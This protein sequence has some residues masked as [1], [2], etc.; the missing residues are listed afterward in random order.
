MRKIILSILISAILLPFTFAGELSPFIGAIDFQDS[1]DHHNAGMIG[2]GYGE[3]IA[4]RLRLKLDIGIFP[5]E[6]ISTGKKTTGWYGAVNAQYLFDPMFSI[7]PFLSAG[8]S[9]FLYADKLNNEIWD[10]GIDAGAGFNFGGKYEYCLEFRN[11]YNPGNKDSDLIFMFGMALDLSEK[12]EKKAEPKPVA[13]K[14]EKKKEPVIIEDVKKEPIVTAPQKVFLNDQKI[15]VG[16]FYRDSSVIGYSGQQRIEKAANILK[17]NP[18][19]KVLLIGY[20]NDV[21][22]KQSEITIQRANAIKQL[23]TDTYEINDD[24][25]SIQDGGVNDISEYIYLNRRVELNFYQ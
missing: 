11:K 1:I 3:N 7:K 12:T 16:R 25:I 2:V 21:E 9:T 22:K 18:E 23:L 14:V 10:K 5:S 6:L 24:K 8:L 13:E 20:T 15:I 19:L 4:D 17:A